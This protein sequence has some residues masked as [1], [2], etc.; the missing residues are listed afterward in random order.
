[1]KLVL[2]RYLCREMLINVFALL[3]ILTDNSK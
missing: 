3:N 1:M 2:I